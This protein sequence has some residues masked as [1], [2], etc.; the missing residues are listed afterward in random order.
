[1]EAPSNW[2]DLSRALSQAAS[3]VA[4]YVSWLP[5]RVTGLSPATVNAVPASVGDGEAVVGEAV[6]GEAVVG[7]RV[8]GEAVAAMAE[9]D[10]V[11]V[12]GAG[13]VAGGVAEHATDSAA[14]AHRVAM[15]AAAPAMRVI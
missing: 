5:L 15:A 1:M 9:P 3:G 11:V 8:G 7:G 12:L 10:D 2:L 4:V 13:P 6:V 14:I